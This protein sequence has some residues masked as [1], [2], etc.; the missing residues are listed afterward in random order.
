MGVM[1]PLVM[2]VFVHAL[3]VYVSP[4]GALEEPEY[5][6]ISVP[7]DVPWASVGA[8]GVES[9]WVAVAGPPGGEVD[10]RKFC[11]AAAVTAA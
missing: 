2:F 3:S 7:P 5:V 4:D 10:P 11:D 1:H 9:I 6:A 8:A